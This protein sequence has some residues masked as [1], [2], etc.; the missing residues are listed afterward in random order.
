VSVSKAGDLMMTSSS[1][2]E[3]KLKINSILPRKYPP[4]GKNTAIVAVMRGKPKYGHHCHRS[5]KHNKQK[6][7]WVLLDYGSDSYLVFVDK[8]KP[9]SFRCVFFLGDP[10]F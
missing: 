1:Q 2:K 8:D 7:V 9:I 3:G 6:K 10:L 4:E 5:K